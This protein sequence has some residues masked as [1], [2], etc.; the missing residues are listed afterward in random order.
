MSLAPIA[1]FAYNRPV[2]LAQ[3]L[4]AL[5]ANPLAR[6]SELF[7][8][9]DGPKTSRD[10]QAVTDVRKSLQQI[11]GFSRVSIQKHS[12]N[13]GL[14]QSIIRGVTSL[15]ER[16]GHVIVLEDD[17]VVAPGFLTFMNQ[18]LSHFM[19]EP[20]VMQ[21]AGYMFPIPQALQLGDVF[22]TRQAASCGWATWARAWKH[23]NVNSD[24]LLKQINLRGSRH[25]FDLDGSYPY[26]DQLKQQAEGQLDAWGVRW[27]ASMFLQQGLCLYPTQSLVSNIG[28]DGSGVHCKRTTALDVSLSSLTAWNLSLPIEESPLG[29][30]M[31]KRFAMEFQ[32]KMR[33]SVIRRIMN[34]VRQFTTG[35]EVT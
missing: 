11:E 10:E 7:V 8:F 32:R 19:A 2:H 18:G 21:I 35:L 1:L 20:R 3:T 6:E 22:L 26:F 12:S 31:L 30:E 29:L 4:S 17:L 5:R 24:E 34:K 23:F 27:H 33:P 9:S 13:L 14:A 15:V 25:E 16:Y 28:M